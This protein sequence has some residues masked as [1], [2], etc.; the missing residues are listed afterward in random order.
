MKTE[1]Q[2]KLN[3]LK[4]PDIGDLLDGRYRIQ[5]LMASGGMGVILRAEQLPMQRPVAIKLLH[6]HIAVSNPKIVE[7]FQQEVR[8]A[9]LL[10]H[11]NTI[12]LYDFG[13][14]SEGLIY[15]AMEYLEGVDLKELI[16]EQGALSAGRALEITRQM[17]DGLAE[18][19]SHDF[20]HRDL[21]PSNVFISENRRGEDFVKLLDFGIAKSLD[22]S[23]VDLT[24]SGSICGTPGY[25]APEYL[26]NEPLEKASDVYAIGLMLL[27]MLTG[28]RVFQ[29][30]AAVQTMMM[31]LQI[32]PDIPPDIEATPLAAVLRKATAKDPF[33]RYADADV[34][35]KALEAIIEQVPHDLYVSDYQYP[36]DP[37]VSD[38][39]MTPPPRVAGRLPA[40]SSS[41]EF[42]EDSRASIPEADMT[43]LGMSSSASSG[44]HQLGPPP[45]P[46]GKQPVGKLPVPGR[47]AEQ[48]AGTES[49][50]AEPEQVEPDQVQPDQVQQLAAASGT[51][52]WLNQRRVWALGGGVAAVLVLALII[53]MAA[54]PGRP[55]LAETSKA[56]APGNEEES[57]AAASPAESGPGELAVKGHASGADAA[58]KSNK[59]RFDL[60][61]D[62]SGAIA[63][64]DDRELG[65]TPL[66]Y[67]VEPDDLPQQV[68]FELDGYREET[69]E[70]THDGV[71][72]VV[73]ALVEAPA[74]EATESATPHV[75]RAAGGTQSPASSR[76]VSAKK[77]RKKKLSDDKVEKVLDELL[78]E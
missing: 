70:L 57:K 22:G 63:R 59:L 54:D 49:K 17:L 68:I 13:E 58:A 2:A 46:V 4:M 29:G 60:D 24:A 8:L 77:K 71:P 78:L 9:K 55:S 14:S 28:Q 21:K 35:L 25:V 41:S 32:D 42:D 26:R 23:E 15:V 20:I 74:E 76:G 61:T 40:E 7:R 31:H 67:E 39:A 1:E 18:A 44:V 73:Q 62:P 47:V 50:D 53:V 66:V 72:L 6:P 43:P 36:S 37:K 48:E 45:L 10:N 11:P 69:R 12:R 3:R 30:E 19:H 56:E 33:K 16:A 65:V 51:S 5:S 64:I 52:T 27:E 75:K 34:M 38:D